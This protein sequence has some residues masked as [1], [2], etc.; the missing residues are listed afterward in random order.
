MVTR[1]I[2]IEKEVKSARDLVTSYFDIVGTKT[3]PTITDIAE[4]AGFELKVFEPED[5]S[6]LFSMY[7][8]EI[9]NN[10]LCSLTITDENKK[11][12]CLS[13]DILTNYGELTKVATMVAVA[14]ALTLY[15]TYESKFKTDYNMIVINVDEMDEILNSED[16]DLLKL[17]NKSCGNAEFMLQLLVPDEMFLLIAAMMPEFVDKDFDTCKFITDNLNLTKN[18]ANLSIDFYLNRWMTEFKKQ[19]LDNDS[20]E[21]METD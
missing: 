10:I 20:Q 12:I 6:A 17:L 7:S 14:V 8:P 16:E 4:A 18:L 2:K 19:M 5:K 3:V 13:Q 15:Y 9:A 21:T 1:T 11:Y